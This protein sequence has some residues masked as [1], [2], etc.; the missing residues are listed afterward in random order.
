MRENEISLCKWSCG[1]A[2]FCTLEAGAGPASNVMV[3]YFSGSQFYNGF[4][5]A[6]KDD[7]YFITLLWQNNGRHNGLISQQ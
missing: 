4:A 2:Q 1:T 6:G 7:V 3:G 5:T